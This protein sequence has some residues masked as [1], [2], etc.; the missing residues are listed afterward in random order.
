[1]ESNVNTLDSLGFNPIP[2]CTFWRYLELKAKPLIT[3]SVDSLV[4]DK[5]Y[6]GN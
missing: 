4:A 5:T 2:P 3:T 6:S 1:M